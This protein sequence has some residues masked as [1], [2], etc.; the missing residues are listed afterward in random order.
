MGEYQ[1][2]LENIEKAALLDPQNATYQER[3]AMLWAKIGRQNVN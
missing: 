2:S 3:I 1:T